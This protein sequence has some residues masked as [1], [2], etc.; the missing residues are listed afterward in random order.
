MTTKQPARVPRLNYVAIIAAAFFLISVFLYWWG[1]DATGVFAES[2]RW[3]LWGGPSTISINGAESAQTL[4]TYGPIIG[5]LVI[6]SAALILIGTIPILSR[7]LI[8]SSLLSVIA[9]IAYAIV[10]NSAVSNVCGQRSNCISGPFG[11]ETF[12]TGGFSLTLNW[13]FQI[14][15]YLE[16]V[17]AVLSIIAIAYQ[18]T[19]IHPKTT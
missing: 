18:R 19:Y 16:V 14:G 17:G 2:F 7:L 6:A 3:S 15:F 1:I 5:V 11:S 4:V 10:V 13:G 9:P 12:G 8:G